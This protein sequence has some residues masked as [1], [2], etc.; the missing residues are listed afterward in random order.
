MAPLSSFGL[1]LSEPRTKSKEMALIK[2]PDCG[3][4]VSS[5]ATACP[6][7]GCPVESEDN[8]PN[9]QGIDGIKE[10]DVKKRWIII[11]AIVALSAVAII[12]A[13]L[14]AHKSDVLGSDGMSLISKK[15]N[16]MLPSI[17]NNGVEPFVLGRSFMDIPP[18]GEYY[19]TITLDRKYGVV[20]GDHYVEITESDIEDYYKTMGSD[21]FEP[22]AIIGIATVF[23][24]K[25]TLMV[26]TYD[27]TGIIDKID[28]YS[29]KLKLD[30]GIHIGM[31]SE[32]LFSQ[33]N[34]MFL[35]TDG[36]AGECWQAYYVS[37]TPPNITLYAHRNDEERGKW[38][39]EVVG[40]VDP[41]RSIFRCVKEGDGD[42]PIFN[43]PL[44]YCKQC[45]IRKM[46]ILQG[47]VDMFKL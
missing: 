46:T 30:N 5:F 35:T 43:V 21:Y 39:G 45:S 3:K 11:A 18:K 15:P 16:V 44:Q 10:K 32:E 19:D 22:D 24:A 14:T 33:Y 27:E 28:V 41:D 26:V 17:T 37:G 7:C 9:E 29:D 31:S 4:E 6:N 25:D 34:A 36:F 8:K 13:L 42:S 38:Y 40:S 2:C 12:I 20:M 47:G 1:I 23:S